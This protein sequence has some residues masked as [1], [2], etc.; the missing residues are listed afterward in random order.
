MLDI[1]VGC[2]PTRR[3]VLRVGALGLGG[4]TLPAWL[5][6]RAARG[7][8]TRDAAVI[9]VYLA[10]GPSHLDSYD[11]KPDAPA[12]FRGEFRAVPT[13]VPGV[14]LGELLPRQASLM[15]KLALVRGVR[16]TSAD[17]GAGAHWILT[18]HPSIDPNPRGNDRPSVGSV[19]ARLRGANRPGLPPYV[20][21]PKPPAFG[22]AAY[23]GPGFNPFSPVAGVGDLDP[24]TGVTL[25]RIDDRRTLLSRL[26][27]FDRHR[28]RSGTMEGLDRFTADAYAMMTGPAARRA[29]DITREPERTLDR[30]G[31]TTLGR[32][33]LLARRLVEAGVTFVTIVDEGWD[34]HTEVFAS[35]R[36]QLP[37]L[38]AALAALVADLHDRALADRVLLLVW[39]EFGRTPRVNPN[40]GRDHWPGAFSDSSPG[41][42]SKPAR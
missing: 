39:G 3:H 38:D 18:G 29:F 36:R 9:Q 4:L 6:A 8:P 26:D 2:E 33:C 34:H 41:A 25:E 14:S 24:P 11:P 17:H 37:P 30:Y 27:R 7:G 32:S 13:A 19:A 28:D 15:D 22:Q 1:A 31:R 23:L 35:C 16:H 10:G 12:E 42:A 40:G 5:R 21:L 20:A